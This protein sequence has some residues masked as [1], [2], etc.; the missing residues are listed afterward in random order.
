MSEWLVPDECGPVRACRSSAEDQIDAGPKCR[1]GVVERS[2]SQRWGVGGLAARVARSR[3]AFFPGVAELAWCGQLLI[4][5][6]CRAVRG[7]VEVAHGDD[8]AAAAR[9]GKKLSCLCL[10]RG[11]EVLGLE[12]GSGESKV[13][14]VEPS[15]DADPAAVERE[16]SDRR[17][18]YRLGGVAS[19]A[20]I[21][22]LEPVRV[23][24][25]QDDVTILQLHR[26]GDRR[27]GP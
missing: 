21:A 13:M 7:G 18:R 16:R 25:H 14:S 12:V 20:R 23:V 10:L 15:L 3:R 1:D 24:V 19:A 11:W 5:G 9:S 8:G 22:P 2:G 4:R 6:R 27:A 26:A 17:R